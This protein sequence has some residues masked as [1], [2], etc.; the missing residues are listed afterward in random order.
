MTRFS[1]LRRISLALLALAVFGLAGPL[2]AAS[3]ANLALEGTATFTQIQGN[4]VS[5]TVVGSGT[6]G[7]FT[8]NFTQ[9]T[10]GNTTTSGMRTIVANGGSLNL[11]YS[12]RFNPKTGTNQGTVQIVGGT[13]RFAGATGSGILVTFTGSPLPFTFL[14]TIN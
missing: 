8:G 10:T 13:G 11:T 2:P 1:S 12:A 6:L 4:T 3:A 9:R 14:G 5:G 7:N